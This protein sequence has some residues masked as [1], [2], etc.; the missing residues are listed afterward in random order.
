VKR[1]SSN[2]FASAAHG[3]TADQS[4][5]TG[6]V[7]DP[8]VARRVQAFRPVPRNTRRPRN[9]RTA[10]RSDPQEATVDSTTLLIVLG[11]FA[12]VMVLLAVGALIWVVKNRPP[13]KGVAATIAA[14]AYAISPVDA[15]P[16]VLLG[17][18]GLVDDLAV[19]VAA[20]LYVRRTIAEVRGTAVT[21][22]PYR[23]HQIHRPR[24][25]DPPKG[26]VR[27]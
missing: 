19:I 11:V 3:K 10:R 24:R 25:D 21:G 14:L 12:L 9:T 7:S 6:V 13:G 5:S 8:V 17:P 4:W 18:I 2:A 26:R 16:E 23:P 1:E 20:F 22:Q 27:G 15:V